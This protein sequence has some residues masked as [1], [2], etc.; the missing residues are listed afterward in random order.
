MVR[1]LGFARVSL[2]MDGPA[3]CH[4]AEVEPSIFHLNFPNIEASN[5]GCE[6]A[7]RLLEHHMSL[8]V[9]RPIHSRLCCEG[10]G[11]LFS[12]CV[13]KGWSYVAKD[14]G[15]KTTMRL[16]NDCIHPNAGRNKSACFHIAENHIRGAWRNHAIAERTPSAPY[17]GRERYENA[18]ISVYKENF[19]NFQIFVKT[20]LG[21]SILVWVHANET[22]MNLKASIEDREGYPRTTF[23]LHYEGKML[24]EETKMTEC[25]IYKNSTIS[26]LQ[27]LRGG[28][29]GNKGPTGPSSYKE[30]THPK[31]PP[32]EAPSSAQTS[33]YLV[34]NLE[35]IPSLEIKYPQVKKNFSTLQSAAIICR[36]NGFWPRSY[37][38]HE[39]I[40]TNWSTRCQIPLCSKGFFVV[41]FESQEDYQKVFLHGP[42][43]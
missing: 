9:P 35:S 39:W 13:V 40:Y 38:L 4:R 31:G 2:A 33:P 3:A 32:V 24:R 7:G 22:V 15:V 18:P 5:H 28:A 14:E 16:P 1:S 29:E 23:Y 26:V 25:R 11:R 19:E 21:K 43:F 27:C 6:G 34:E 30:A 42:W 20:L 36:F 12:Y 8:G 37:D 17:C 41:Q 10:K